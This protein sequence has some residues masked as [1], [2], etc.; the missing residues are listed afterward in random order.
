M[1]EKRQIKYSYNRILEISHDMKMVTTIDNRFYRRNGVYFPSITSVLQMYPK[2]QHYEKWLKTVGFASEYIVKK[3]QEDGIATHE[4]IEKWLNGEELNFLNSSGNPQYD[5]DV[6]KMLLRFIEFWEIYNP[7][8]IEA[9]VHL[10]SEEL[11]VA[12]TCDLVCEIDGELWIIDFKTGNNLHLTNELQIDVY[13]KCYEE[14]FG[15]KIQRRGLLWL[16]SSTR[17]L[18]KGKMQG[19]GWNMIEPTRTFDENIEI[20]KTVKKLWDLENPTPKPSF[21]TFNTTVKRKL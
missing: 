14:C 20:F 21:E 15:K 18:S 4:L 12:G 10:F 6:W 13:S 9:E 5:S 7:K 2:G 1:Q 16:K 3:S 17:K 11:K 8:L 19:N